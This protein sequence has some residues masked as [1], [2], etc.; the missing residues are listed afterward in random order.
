MATPTDLAR[1]MHTVVEPIH[2]IAYFAAP[3]AAAWER[4]GLD[5]R[6]QGY[7]AGR[8][9]PLGRVGAG[10]VTA[11]FFNF[12][13]AVVG[14]VLDGLWDVADPATVLTARAEGM[15]ATL[16]E[17]EVPTDGLEEATALARRAAEAPGFAAGRPLGAANLDV[18]P[19]GEPRADLW[20]ALTALREHRG[21]GHIAALITAGLGPLD[22]VVLYAAWQG[23]VS[24]RFLQKT[25]GWDDAAWEAAE[26]RLREAGHLD[27]DA[28]L[29]DA[30]RALR[31]EVE[32]H[33]DAAAAAPYVHLG[34]DDTR[35]L[36][37]LL[38]PVA[39]A[40]AAGYPRPFTVP[41][42]MPV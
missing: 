20:Q 14:W 11:T 32:A 19:S 16:E 31:D 27:D 22:A 13:P 5:P 42:R 30:G 9:A 3:Q 8:A 1:A 24:R 29:T 28:A 23:S 12:N 39:A 26:D 17:L 6:S 33:T 40:V 34:E 35:R 37:E 2:A 25:R 41:E 18:T 7:F 38:Q 36:W 21:D 4:L 10:T 15:A